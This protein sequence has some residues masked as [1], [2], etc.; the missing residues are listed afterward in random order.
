MRLFH[1]VSLARWV[2]Q[3]SGGVIA[4]ILLWATALS[5]ILSGAEEVDSPLNGRWK[6]SFTMPD[7]QTVSPVAKLRYD[8]VTLS[9]T[10]RFR[11]A[12]ETPISEAR[13]EGSSIRF[14]VVREQGDRKVTTRYR[15]TVTGD[16]IRG[17][18][19]SDWDGS[20][21][22]YPW[23]AKRLPDMVEGTWKWTNTLRDHK[24]EFSLKAHQEGDKVSGKLSGRKGLGVDIKHGRFR[25]GEWTFEAERERDGDRFISKFRGR[26]VG[27][28]VRGKETVITGGQEQVIEWVAT[29]G[30]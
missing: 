24:L 23:E 13:I 5:T 25:D 30:D 3:A 6:W 27:D 14:S 7:G 26:V 10:S 18:I 21:H 28:I 17:T 20:K 8:G 9:G 4:G 2:S 11:H 15:G 22:T 19:E 1:H 12:T 29:R 16:T